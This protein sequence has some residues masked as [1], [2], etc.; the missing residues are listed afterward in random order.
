MVSYGRLTIDIRIVVF[1]QTRRLFSYGVTSLPDARG[2]M[3]FYSV[4]AS[5]CVVHVP[6]RSALSIDVLVGEILGALMSQWDKCFM[7]KRLLQR[8]PYILAKNFLDSI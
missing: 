8:C 5:L 6:M 4:F 2:D 1:A 7:H 3:L